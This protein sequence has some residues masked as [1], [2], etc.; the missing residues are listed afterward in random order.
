MRGYHGLLC[1][2]IIKS[3]I[4]LLSE[5]MIEAKKAVL[6][7]PNLN[8]LKMF[9][10][11]MNDASVKMML[12]MGQSNSPQRTAVTKKQCQSDKPF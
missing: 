11:L 9:H 5:V 2:L 3:Y 4:L 7:P 8:A 10:K 1:G 6:L 12:K